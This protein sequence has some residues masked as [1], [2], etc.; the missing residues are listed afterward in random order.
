MLLSQFCELPGSLAV[1]TLVAPLAVVTLNSKLKA[2]PS[3]L[4]HETR[5]L[6]PRMVTVMFGY[7][8]AT[9]LLW[10]E[11]SVLPTTCFG[12]RHYR[13][14]M[15][16]WVSRVCEHVSCCRWHLLLLAAG[17][18]SYRPC[19]YGT[20]GVRAAANEPG[21][22]SG[23]T[24]HYDAPSNQ[25]WLLFG[26]GYLFNAAGGSGILNDVWTMKVD[27]LQYTWC[28]LSLRDHCFT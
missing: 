4:I 22:R 12:G 13:P 21:G 25:L 6:P 10:E 8:A 18:T 7:G 16:G 15:P 26:G 23:H 2:G 14:T 27:S 5:L 28:E 3:C 17:T 20:I 11:G 9:S 24:L 1:Q 19:V